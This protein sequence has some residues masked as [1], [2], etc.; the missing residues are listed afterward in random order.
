MKL[1]AVENHP[2]EAAM[3]MIQSALPPDQIYLCTNNVNVIVNKY[4]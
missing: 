4:K 2:A 3:K 1:L